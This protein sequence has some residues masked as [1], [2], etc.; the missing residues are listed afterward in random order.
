[1]CPRSFDPGI[2]VEKQLLHLVFKIQYSFFSKSQKRI[3]KKYL[4]NPLINNEPKAISY[5]KFPC[6]MHIAKALRARTTIRNVV[7]WVLFLGGMILASILR[8]YEILHSRTPYQPTIKLVRYLWSFQ[9][10]LG[11]LVHQSKQLTTTTCS[12]QIQSR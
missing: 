7:V 12:K 2:G 6:I 1:M 4:K 9:D 10:I 8:D 3:A 5:C 11:G